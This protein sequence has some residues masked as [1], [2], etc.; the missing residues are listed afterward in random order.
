M[1]ADGISMPP[2]RDF[3]MSRWGRLEGASAA[4][5]A[6]TAACFCGGSDARALKRASRSS[7]SWARR[8]LRAAA[9][10]SRRAR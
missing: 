9:F 6:V 7:Q 10:A 8:S 5:R 3:G 2:K 4:I 1:P